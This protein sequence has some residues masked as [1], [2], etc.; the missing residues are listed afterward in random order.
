LTS[1]LLLVFL[2]SL[3]PQLLL[4]VLAVVGTDCGFSAV[5]GVPAVA[6]ILLVMVFPLI[7]ASLLL[8]ATPDFPDYSCNAVGPAVNGILTAVVYP[9]DTAVARVSY[10]V[11]IM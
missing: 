8:L 1:F 5:V 2:T 11:Y 9:G 3:A 7:M 6:G 4:G 10:T